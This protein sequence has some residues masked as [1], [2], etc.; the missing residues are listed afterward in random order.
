MTPFNLK[1][2]PMPVAILHDCVII[3]MI[4]KILN[5]AV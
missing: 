4:C 5:I 3:F 2:N 1:I